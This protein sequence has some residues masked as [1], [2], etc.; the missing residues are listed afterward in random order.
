MIERLVAELNHWKSTLPESLQLR[1]LTPLDKGY[2]GKMHLHQN[3][4]HALIILFRS[5]LVAV[6][7]QRLSKAFVPQDDLPDLDPQA[8]NLSMECRNAAQNMIA[9]IDRVRQTKL[10]A[11]FSWT[12]F[13]GCS[14]AILITL[15]YRVI[16]KDFDYEYIIDSGLHNLKVLAEASKPAQLALNFVLEFKKIVEEAVDQPHH[17]EPAS[18]AAD[19]QRENYKKWLSSLS[20]QK[21]SSVGENPERP[22]SA[23]RE[24][25]PGLPGEVQQTASADAAGGVS[26]WAGG[27]ENHL[28]PEMSL[29]SDFLLDES[30]IM[31]LS[32][33]D[34][35]ASSLF[36]GDQ[37][38]P[39]E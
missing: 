12:D 30:Q 17:P 20:V 36:A 24:T 18:N 5:A 32:G 6:A 4:S 3:Y 21:N 35:L 22:N 29:E 16:E 2:R 27:G 34:F 7:R 14:T 39:G 28:L 1:N 15:L 9:N 26:T 11:R 19:G 38:R 10:L 23:S 31:S 8:L 37:L 13:Q 33:M 25:W